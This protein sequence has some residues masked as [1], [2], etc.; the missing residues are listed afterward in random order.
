MG[1]KI[2][3]KSVPFEIVPNEHLQAHERAM[4]YLKSAFE[5]NDPELFQAA[6]QDVISV[7]KPMLPPMPML[8]KLVESLQRHGVGEAII[9]AVVAD[10]SRLVADAA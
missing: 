3:P 7:Q 1:A 2:M 10:I 5:E 8:P 4:S 6:L 9:T